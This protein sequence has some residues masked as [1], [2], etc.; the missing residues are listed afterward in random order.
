MP[1]NTNR[2]TFLVD[3]MI[4]WIWILLFVSVGL[5]AADV[6]VTPVES[7]PPEALNWLNLIISGLT[8]MV[9]L[10]IRKLVPKIPKLVLPLAV[11]LI[12]MGID[13]VLRMASV[14]TGG[15]IWGLVYGAVGTWF[16]EAQKG[17]RV[18][19][20]EKE[21]APAGPDGSAKLAEE[22]AKD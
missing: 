6:P 20:A 3:N 9:V 15:P 16:Y 2:A 11:P 14:E 8:P 17:V 12:G 10:G 21:L 18:A 5:Y 19:I 4:R 7:P 22:K 13:W 1:P